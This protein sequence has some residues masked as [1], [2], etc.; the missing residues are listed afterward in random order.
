MMTDCCEFPQKHHGAVFEK[1]SDK[2]Y[3]RA[4]I[5]VQGEISRGFQLPQGAFPRLRPSLAESGMTAEDVATHMPMA[6]E[7]QESFKRMVQIKG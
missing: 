7:T 6:F 1:Y 5:F 4:S 3:K 2:R